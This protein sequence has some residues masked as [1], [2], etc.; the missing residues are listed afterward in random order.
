M[1]GNAASK[2]GEPRGNAAY[3][4]SGLHRDRGG[5]LRFQLR[6]YDHHAVFDRVDNLDH[7]NEGHPVLGHDRWGHNHNRRVDDH[8][9]G[10]NRV[11]DYDLRGHHHH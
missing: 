1:L 10:D 8:H 11:L 5:R 2:G 9:G 7:K 4:G 6:G 3:I